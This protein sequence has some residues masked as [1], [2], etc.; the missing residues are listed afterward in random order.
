MP[1]FK[2]QWNNFSP[3]LLADLAASCKLEGDPAESLKSKYG[4]RPK[5]DFIKENLPCL[6]DGWLASSLDTESI[7]NIAVALRSRS[8]GSDSED[9]CDLDYIRSCRNTKTLR[10]VLLRYFIESGERDSGFVASLTSDTPTPATSTQKTTPSLPDKVIDSETCDLDSML[11]F[12]SI[13]LAN[14]CNV[15]PDTF[16]PDDEGD[17]AIPW[18]SALLY[19][20]ASDNKPEVLKIYGVILRDIPKGQDPG[21]LSRINLIN[22]NLSIGKF[23]Y[24]QPNG[25]IGFEHSLLARG[26][27]AQSLA[28]TVV[29]MCN[30]ADA[31]DHR[32]QQEFGGRLM[33][34]Q[35][36][37]DVIEV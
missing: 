18:G 35:V 5:D 36:K 37:D 1:R 4:A 23:I 22:G 6:Y 27:T 33:R 34:N 19:L 9:Q 14:L 20:S 21:I 10:E 12:A 26:L 30:W 17:I 3:K 31:L 16:A 28:G 7:K 32:L 29:E 8:L 25:I 2:F 24:L 15:S 13:T 11:A